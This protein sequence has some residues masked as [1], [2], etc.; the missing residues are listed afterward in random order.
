MNTSMSPAGTRIDGWPRASRSPRTGWATFVL[1]ASLHGLFGQTGL[2]DTGFSSGRGPSGWVQKM[3]VSS[4]GKIVIAGPFG[5]YDGVLRNR[6]AQLHS[7]G[8]LDLSFDPGEALAGMLNA[9]AVLY[10]P[11]GKVL[12]AGWFFR[13]GMFGDRLIRLTAQGDIDFTFTGPLAEG[14]YFMSLA[15]QSDGRILLGGGFTLGSSPTYSNLVRLTTSGDV[16]PTFDASI[17]PDGTVNSVALASDGSIWIGG[18]FQTVQ[19]QPRSHLARLTANGQL[20]ATPQASGWNGPVTLVRASLE[21]IVAGAPDQLRVYEAGGAVLLPFANVSLSGAI[22]DAV[23]QS[24]GKVVVVGYLSSPAQNLIRFNPDGTFDEMYGAAGR[25]Q[26]GVDAACALPGD[27]LLIGGDFIV[28]GNQATERVARLFGDVPQPAAPQIRDDLADQELFL[29]DQFRLSVTALG[30]PMAYQWFKDGELIEGATRPT[31][32]PY[33][34]GVASAIEAGRYHV[35]ISNN[36]GT[37][38]SRT[39]TLVVNGYPVAITQQPVG[40]T[41][42]ETLTLTLTV[43]VTGSEPITYQWYHDG[44]P[45]EGANASTFT[46]ANAVPLN[47]GTYRVNVSNPWSAKSS[48]QVVVSVVVA[49]T[50][51]GALNVHRERPS[52]PTDVRVHSVR[53]MDDGRILTVGVREAAPNQYV[54]YIA[55]LTPDGSLDPSFAVIL[56]PNDTDASVVGVLPNG[57]LMVSVW[58]R[59]MTAPGE[60]VH[61]LIVLAPNGSRVPGFQVPGGFDR[62]VTHGVAQ[63]DGKLVVAGTFQLIGGLPR[64]NIARLHPNGSADATFAAPH[65]QNTWPVALQVLPDDRLYFAEMSSGST[66]SRLVTR[67][68]SNGARDTTFNPVPEGFPPPHASVVQPLPDGR[69]LVGGSFSKVNGQTRNNLVR[70]NSNGTVDESFLTGLGPNWDVHNIFPLEGGSFLICGRFTTFNGENRP[71]IARINS[72]GAIDSGFLLITAPGDSPGSFGSMALLQDG[73]IV[74][75]GGYQVINGF[76]IDGLAVLHGDRATVPTVN[77]L[78]LPPAFSP[79]DR[80]RL[81]LGGSPGKK[82]RLQKSEAL[83]I[84][85]DLF[86]YTAGS[87][88]QAFEDSTSGRVGSRYYRVINRP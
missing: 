70:L 5:S 1:L 80:F 19:G 66:P 22:T 33:G 56:G 21:K 9:R 4:T 59:L 11:D 84:W 54:P 58:R 38:I 32:P 52:N 49:P 72:A 50:S 15:R 31:L 83:P 7:D 3:D 79:G 67:L 27:K 30:Y 14:A 28:V 35:V 55:K 64:T 45:L 23:V 42:V 88:S 46:L 20:A 86:D 62:Q 73:D 29:G 53:L 16:D 13:D 57:N 63:S 69:V 75:T 6:I 8:S 2:L 25:P 81:S 65:T 76:T 44:E 47:S 68:F 61:D 60:S 77:P 36:L 71:L 18:E 78:L 40:K 12:L 51:P 39:N 87:V 26:P 34:P 17:N 74:V 41:L 10:Q 48:D 24:S 37:T 43:G 85:T 82:Y